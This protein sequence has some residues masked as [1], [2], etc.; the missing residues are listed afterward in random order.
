MFSRSFPIFFAI[1]LLIA[2]PFVSCAKKETREATLGNASITDFPQE[3]EM[4]ETA[5]KNDP[6][7]VDILI[8]LGNLY[9][10]WGQDEVDREGNSAQPYDKWMRGISCYERALE[11]DPGNVN[12]RTDMATLMRYAGQI[13]QAI[14]EYR[15]ALKLDPRHP[16]ARINLILAL[17]ESKHDY[18]DALS[19]YDNLIKEVP[20]QKENLELSQEVGAFRQ[21]MKDGEK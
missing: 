9:Y 19:E 15:T 4:M 12:V 20:D 13:D 7:N 8:Q 17:G 6:K 5:L 10:D 21:A 3:A 16:Q 18:K 14:S 2:M 1:S 11:I